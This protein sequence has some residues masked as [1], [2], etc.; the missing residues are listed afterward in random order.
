[1]SEPY[2]V[3]VSSGVEEFD[4]FY[5]NVLVERSEFRE[6]CHKVRQDAKRF[7]I[8]PDKIEFN[9]KKEARTGS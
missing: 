7:D 4:M 2:C 5:S 9:V 6:Y 1:M 3:M 8:D